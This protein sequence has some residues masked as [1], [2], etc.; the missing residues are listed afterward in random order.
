MRALGAAAAATA[1]WAL[2]LA[3]RWRA[4][5]QQA[6]PPAKSQAGILAERGLKCRGLLQQAGAQAFLRAHPRRLLEADGSHGCLRARGRSLGQARRQLKLGFQAEAA[7]SL[8]HLIHRQIEGGCVGVIFYELARQEK[9]HPF[10]A[11]STIITPSI[12]LKQIPIS[13]I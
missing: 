10:T 6:F 9:L 13:T 12:S 11:D 1:G 4:R 2:T 3:A 7:G 8:G 5:L